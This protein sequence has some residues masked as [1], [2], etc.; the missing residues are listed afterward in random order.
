MEREELMN[1]TK[2][3][4]LM[5]EIDKIESKNKG[6][7]PE[8]FDSVVMEQFESIPDGFIDKYFDY[9]KW[10]ELIEAYLNH[11][12]ILDKIRKCIFNFQTDVR[13]EEFYKARMH[14]IK[15]L[16]NKEPSIYSDDRMKKSVCVL[17]DSYEMEL[18]FSKVEDFNL[19]CHTYMEIC[20]EYGNDINFKA[21]S[22][23]PNL[24]D[25]FLTKY[26][27][28]VKWEIVSCKHI[29]SK[30][31]ILKWRKYLYFNIITEVLNDFEE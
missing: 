18:F 29:L 6:K 20:I 21:I 28:R 7:L 24:S 3:A 26:K 15:L 8:N 10:D 12:L 31:F 4:T 17:N 16:I 9:I 13:S 5:N 30:K 2:L 25:D 23:F 14:M 19:Y 27:N 1:A 22:T 11:P